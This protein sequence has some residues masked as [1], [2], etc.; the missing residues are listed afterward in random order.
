MH[1]GTA[2]YLAGLRQLGFRTFDCILD[3]SYDA[4]EKDIDRWRG[5]FE[6][7]KFLSQQDHPAVMQK[8]KPV[9]DHNHNRLLELKQ[10]ILQQM[11]AMIQSNLK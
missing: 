1:F 4:V 10:E 2:N 3:E 7:V 8:I 9:V 5:A 11:Q 6:Q